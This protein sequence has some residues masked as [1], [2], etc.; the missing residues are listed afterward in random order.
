MDALESFQ[1]NVRTNTMQKKWRF[2][3]ASPLKK[4]EILK[5]DEEGTEHLY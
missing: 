1:N 5:V 2:S 4:K 3:A